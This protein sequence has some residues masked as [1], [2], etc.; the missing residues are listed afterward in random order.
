MSNE[1]T[2]PVVKWILIAVIVVSFCVV[3]AL[4]LIGTYP[5][6]EYRAAKELE[7][8]GFNIGYARQGYQVW[9]YPIGVSGSGL[10]ITED[11][12]RLICQL[13]HLRLL[14]FQRCDL[15]GLYLD[16]IGNRR[17]L[18]KFYCYDVTQLPADEITKLTV[19]PINEF[20]F[21]NVIGLGD[22]HLNDSDLMNFTKW[23]KLEYLDLPDNAGITDA[24]FEYFGKIASLKKLNLT[25]TSVTQKGVDD[26]R[27]KRPDVYV[28]F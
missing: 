13:R 3:G 26:F 18:R 1:T 27:K 19:C 11:D 22:V 5:T 25:G 21:G 8:R 12:S 28:E 14:Y 16:D 7:K 23:T 6:E 17:E 24:G 10:S 15:S 20:G 4:F 2:H 9:R